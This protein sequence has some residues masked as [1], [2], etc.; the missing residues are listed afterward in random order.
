MRNKR[1]DAL[2]LALCLVLAGCGQR[3]ETKTEIAESIGIQNESV[4]PDTEDADA[5]DS[6]SET[7]ETQNTKTTAQEPETEAIVENTTEPKYLTLDISTMG[8]I[9]ADGDAVDPIGLTILSEEENGVSWANDW[10][11]SE[12]LSLPMI[13]TDWNSFYDDHYQYQWVDDELYIYETG[14]GNCIYVLD[15]PTDQWYIN[16]NN[17][18]LE[19]GI[20]YGASVR[21]GYAQSNTCFM[22]AYDLEN[23]KLLWRSADQTYNS[24][25]FVVKG[26]V[27]LCGYGFTAEPDYLY[28][29][30]RN[31]GEVI[32][33][34]L[35]KKGTGSDH[36]TGWE[37]LCPYLQLQLCDRD[38]CTERILSGRYG[39][40]NSDNR[41]RGVNS[42]QNEKNREALIAVL[43]VCLIGVLVTV[44]IIA[45]VDL[46]RKHTYT[47]EIDPS[48]YKIIKIEKSTTTSYSAATETVDTD[49]IYV[50]TVEYQVDGVTY[51]DTLDMLTGTELAKTLYGRYQTDSNP[52]EVLGKLYY[53]PKKPSHIGRYGDDSIFV[54]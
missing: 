5:K 53:S 1:K 29:I 35:L 49:S 42:R 46:Y 3:A 41:K 27:I 2:F 22:F 15:Y 45:A 14:T 12:N 26:D 32:D 54:K 34:L 50:V 6:V 10:Y 48:E 19:D 30:N 13:G 21:K 51:T 43:T 31:T 20:F 38:G 17:A 37:A 44:V 47:A 18:Y 52:E 16:G 24:M 4:M 39:L 23:D 11:D 9:L 25:N 8:E 33:R 36:R 28:Q 40:G 7:G